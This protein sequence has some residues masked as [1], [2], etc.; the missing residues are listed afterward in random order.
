M[1]NPQGNPLNYAF[2]PFDQSQHERRWERGQG[3]ILRFRKSDKYERYDI[4]KGKAPL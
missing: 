3:L 2:R 1:L 4:F